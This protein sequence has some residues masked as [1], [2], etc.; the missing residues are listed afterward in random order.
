MGRSI[1]CRNAAGEQAYATIDVIADGARGDHAVRQR[2]GR[3]ATDRETIALVH[4]RHDDHLP[5]QAGERGSVHRLFKGLVAQGSVQQPL[6]GEHPYRDAHVRTEA[7][8][9]FPQEG[10][11]LFEV[12]LLGHEAPLSMSGGYTS[13]TIRASSPSFPCLTSRSWNVMAL[14]GF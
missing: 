2:R 14:I 6:V 10:G 5:Y 13:K 3:H 8:G 9:D 11:K 12:H 7:L 1:I 4:I